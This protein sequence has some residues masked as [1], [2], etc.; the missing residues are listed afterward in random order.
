MINTQAFLAAYKDYETALREHGKD[1]K[2]IEEAA[3]EQTSCRM[4]I[5]RQ[6][7]NYLSHN[8]DPGFLEISDKQV[9]WI[10][11]LAK[12]EWLSEDLVKDHLLT[13][14]RALLME[15]DL[16]KDCLKR[17]VAVKRTTLPV[18][19]TK[20]VLGA[21]S[22]MTLTKLYLKD[23]NGCLTK[24]HQALMEPITLVSEQTRMADL[25]NVHAC[26][27]CTKDGSHIG[28]VLGVLAADL[29]SK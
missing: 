10:Q 24:K 2:E 25:I 4:R 17:M 1:Y 12:A 5:S 3:D 22:L 8:E 23:E 6:I 15:G 27:C 29:Q 28:K 19:N 18:A 16:I 14:R 21:I 26:V 7:R 20:E 13:P 9:T 11:D